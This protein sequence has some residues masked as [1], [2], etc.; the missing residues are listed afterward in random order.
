MTLFSPLEQQKL[1]RS[2][3]SYASVGKCLEKWKLLH[4]MVLYVN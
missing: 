2:I 3:Q 1:E 4:V